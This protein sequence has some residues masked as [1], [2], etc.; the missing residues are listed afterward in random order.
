MIPESERLD[1]LIEGLRQ[2][3]LEDRDTLIEKILYKF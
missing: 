3:T 1:I 2:E